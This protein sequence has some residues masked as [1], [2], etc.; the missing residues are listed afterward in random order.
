MQSA[1]H[2]FLAAGLIAG[3]TGTVAPLLA[4]DDTTPPSAPDHAFSAPY[5]GPT[6]DQATGPTDN[7]V[8]FQTF[9]DALSPL[10]NWI[11]T[12]DYGYVWQ[13]T[14]S[15]P[16]WAPYTVGHWVYTDDGWTWASD[17]PWGWATYHYGRWINLQNIGWVWV[18]GYTWAPAWVSWRS[19][20]GYVGWAPLP[21]DSFAGIDYSNDGSTDDD[22]YHIGGDSDYF[23]GIGPAYYIFL[24]IRCVGYRHYHDWY[25]DRHDNFERINHTTNV[26]NINVTR[27]SEHGDSAG[28]DPFHRVTA[29]G[30]SLD[31]VNATSSTPLTRVRL[32]NTS[33]PGGDNLTG[34]ALA[35]YAPSIRPGADARPTRVSGAVPLATIN[36]GTDI[37]RPLA[38]NAS[39]MPA[40]A[41]GPQIQRARLAQN[42]APAAAKVVTDISPIQP[43]LKAPLTNLKPIAAPLRPS[44]TFTPSP[45]EFPAAPHAPSATVFNSSP[46]IYPQQ[47]YGQ[48]M[49][50]TRIYNPN[51][52]APTSPTTSPSHPISTETPSAPRAYEHPSAPGSSS[53]TSAPIE[54]HPTPSPTSSPPPG[55]YVNPSP[56]R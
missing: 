26:T 24:P 52:T 16:D 56:N 5:P 30:P 55:P 12:S 23:Y 20:D 9:Y 15:D 14:V 36:H 25:C 48:G 44:S 6:P 43:V 21:P 40:A 38:V 50:P 35:L 37:L 28:L 19:G 1:L 32:V 7:T 2:A 42:N 8:T 18:P 22:G 11:Q 13:P 47:P 53:A 3:L 46:G 39:L 31:D 10:G 4:Q 45:S 54:S 34:D 27:H 41:T 33:Q 51:P 29:G 17:E 49:A